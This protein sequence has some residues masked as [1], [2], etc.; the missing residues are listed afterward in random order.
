MWDEA[1]QVILDLQPASIVVEYEKQEQKG[2]LEELSMEDFIEAL[3]TCHQVIYGTPL[4][5]LEDFNQNN[6]HVRWILT[7]R[8]LDQAEN[9]VIDEDLVCKNGEM[10][11]IKGRVSKVQVE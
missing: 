4:P 8:S 7:A 2:D 1:I 6:K 5:K 10:E 11:G 9:V 3:Q